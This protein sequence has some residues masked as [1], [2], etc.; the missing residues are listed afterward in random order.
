MAMT[1]WEYLRR[2]AAPLGEVL[3]HQ[4]RLAFT[5]L[6]IG[7]TFPRYTPGVRKRMGFY[8]VMLRGQVSRLLLSDPSYRPLPGALDEPVQTAT[9]A[10]AGETCVVEVKVLRTLQGAH[11]NYLPKSGDGRFD[12]RVTARVELPSELDGILAPA[13]PVVTS[14]AAEIDLT[15]SHTRHESWGGKRFVNVQVESLDRAL[16]RP[17]TTV[18]FRFPIER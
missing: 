14:G 18:K 17:G 2:T 6:P 3:G 1:E 9:A 15:R 5:S 11:L 10:L 13:S 7:Y 16:V 8:D 12:W 4:Y